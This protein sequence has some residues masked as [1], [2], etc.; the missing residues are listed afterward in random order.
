MRFVRIYRRSRLVV[1]F[2]LSTVAHFRF[3]FRFLLKFT[4]RSLDLY[5]SRSRFILLSYSRSFP[6]NLESEG[7]SP[8]P[9]ADRESESKDPVL[10]GRL[11]LTLSL[12]VDARSAEQWGRRGSRKVTGRRKITI[13][14]STDRRAGGPR[15]LIS[16]VYQSPR[17][18]R[19]YPVE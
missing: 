11:D 12:A 10:P 13:N 6:A 8:R 2:N 4:S 19:V 16:R 15:V 7:A 14:P 3:F 17:V 1:A 9:R 18:F 5:Y